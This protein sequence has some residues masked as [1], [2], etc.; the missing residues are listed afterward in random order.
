MLQQIISGGTATIVGT[1]PLD[2]G[3]SN[4]AGVYAAIKAGYDFAVRDVQLA[5]GG[6][7]PMRTAMELEFSYLGSKENIPLQS[8]PTKVGRETYSLSAYAVMLNGLIKFEDLPVV[9]YFGGGVGAAVLYSDNHQITVDGYTGTSASYNA[10]TS[11]EDANN[12]CLALQAIVGIE[13]RLVDG[14]SIYLEYKFLAYMD[15]QFVYGKNNFS[16][17]PTDAGSNSS[18]NFI[19]QQILSGGLKWSF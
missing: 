10:T 6:P 4:R 8:D 5:F 7:T 9:P 15:P 17:F 12:V 19:A 13:R 3:S 1:P 14:L 18:A 2:Q 16:D 11:L